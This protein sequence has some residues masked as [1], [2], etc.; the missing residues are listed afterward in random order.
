MELCD[1]V[2]VEGDAETVLKRLPSRSVQSIVTSPPY[3]GLRDCNIS[4]QLPYKTHNQ[5]R[6]SIAANAANDRNGPKHTGTRIP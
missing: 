2:I 3:Q 4:P 6:I 5:G 1:S